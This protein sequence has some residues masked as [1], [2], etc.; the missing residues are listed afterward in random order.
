VSETIEVEVESIAAGGDGVAR[1][2]GLVV[3][4]PRTAP[5]DAG[6]AEVELKGRFARGELVELTRAS[7]LRTEPPCPHYTRDRCGGCQIQHIGYEAQLAAKQRIIHDGLTRIGGR[8]VALPAVRASPQQWRYRRKLTLAIR[9]RGAGWSAGLHPYDAP[10]RVFPLQ[11]CPIT[12]E[13]VLA[14]WREVMA[15]SAHFPRA[16]ELRGAVRLLESGSAF[17]LEGGSSWPH[18]A[19]FFDVVPSISALW[20]AREN[21]R[22]ELLADRRTERTPGASLA[23]VNPAVADMLRECVVERVA[24]HRPETVV[25]AYAGVGDT[26][27]AL[28]SRGVKVTAIELDADAAAWCAGRLPAGSRSI[29]GRV[30]DHLAAALPADVVLLNPP[31]AGVHAT[32]AA[33]VGAQ[34]PPTRAVVYVSCNPATLARDVARM[35]AMRIASLVAF[36]MFPQTA[37]VEKVCELVPEAA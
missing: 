15:A 36:D 11:D 9:P 25:D 1:A 22:A 6:R 5:G 34:G 20:W 21:R 16:R 27:A 35:P 23:Q 7:P 13:R 10:G 3:S 32:V 29:A 26:A 37:H 31:R 28:A 12:D 4:L 18:A 30:E 33:A 19:K 17:V 24:G 2:H 8:T 14:T